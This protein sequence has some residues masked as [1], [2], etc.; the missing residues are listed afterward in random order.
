MMDLQFL[1]K[2]IIKE[3]LKKQDS[4]NI[5]AKKLSQNKS[6]FNFDKVNKT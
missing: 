4:L 6:I 1:V 5:L 3:P 2:L